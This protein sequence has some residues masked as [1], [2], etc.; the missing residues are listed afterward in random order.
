MEIKGPVMEHERLEEQMNLEELTLERLQVLDMAVGL[1]PTYSGCFHFGVRPDVGTIGT[2]GPLNTFMIEQKALGEGRIPLRM[3]QM[4]Y[5]PERPFDNTTGETYLEQIGTPMY[6]ENGVK[7]DIPYEKLADES[8]TYKPE[9]WTTKK[10]KNN[11]TKIQNKVSSKSTKSNGYRNDS[12]ESSVEE[13]SNRH[14]Y[15][16]NYDYD[17]DNS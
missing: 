2:Y 3:L 16:T 14:S 12:G 11:Q 10:Y 8:W 13:K 4:K 17:S 5:H 9:D 15:E 7:F 6:V 1:T